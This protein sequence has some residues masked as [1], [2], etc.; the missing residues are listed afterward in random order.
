MCILAYAD[1]IVL[2]AKSERDLQRLLNCASN[3]CNKWRVIINCDKSK[4]MHFRRCNVALTKT[5]FHIGASTLESVENYRYLGL[6]LDSHMTG[7]QWIEQLSKSSSKALGG[8]ISKTR[9]NYDLGYQTFTKLYH[10][11]V[12][13]IMVYGCGTWSIG[14]DYRKLDQIH[15]RCIRFYCGLPEQVPYLD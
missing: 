1:D 15:E 3:W 10:S 9:N 7:D 8:L 14:G 11:L 12:V 4:I 5:V 13:P 2:L 6:T